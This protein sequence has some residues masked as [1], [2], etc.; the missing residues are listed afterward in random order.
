M[1]SIAF[2]FWS[3]TLLLPIICPATKH[4]PHFIFIIRIFSIFSFH[5][6]LLQMLCNFIL[7]LSLFFVQFILASSTTDTYLFSFIC[8]LRAAIFCPFCNLFFIQINLILVL[9]FIFI[10][11]AIYPFKPPFFDFF[12]N[13][14]FLTLFFTFFA[15]FPFFISEFIYS[16]SLHFFLGQSFN[17]YFPLTP[18]IIIDNLPLLNVILGKGY[19]PH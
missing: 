18:Q 16:F 3:S 6:N 9:Q 8:P 19:F 14:S 2:R 15:F 13:F 1:I 4:I 10:F 12:L 7:S 17:N 11:L 5:L